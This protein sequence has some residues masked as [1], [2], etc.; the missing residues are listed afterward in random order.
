VR[1][2]WDAVA[3]SSLIDLRIIPKGP[4]S[5]GTVRSTLRL[6]LETPTKATQHPKS[7]QPAQMQTPNQPLHSN[8]QK[9]DYKHPS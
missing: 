6:F 7:C 4:N 8:Q 5:Q 2:T 3:V 1:I 9:L